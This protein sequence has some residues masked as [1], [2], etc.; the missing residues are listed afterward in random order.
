MIDQIDGYIDKINGGQT[1]D[2]SINRYTDRQ[3]IDTYIHTQM[4]DDK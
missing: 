3:M 2:R 1:D 4:I